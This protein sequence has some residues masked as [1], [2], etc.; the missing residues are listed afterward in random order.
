MEK[1][2]YKKDYEEYKYLEKRFCYECSDFY[3]GAICGYIIS[4][5]EKDNMEDIKLKRAGV[6]ELDKFTE[7]KI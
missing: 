1:S 7:V 4:A 6:C 5:N 3:E 2:N